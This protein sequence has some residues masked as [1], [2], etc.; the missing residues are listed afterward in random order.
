MARAQTN[1]ATSG[2]AS[3]F[4]AT[5]AARVEIWMRVTGR[6]RQAFYRC[7]L[8]G[9]TTWQA[10]GVPLAERALKAGSIDLP[11]LAAATVERYDEDE[12]PAHPMAAEFAERARALN[13]DIDALNLCA[14][15]G[16]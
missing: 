1:H 6:R 13:S 9:V 14:R 12:A 4:V 11:G 7:K 16:A 8:A 5:R 3:P 10:M 15:G 2:R